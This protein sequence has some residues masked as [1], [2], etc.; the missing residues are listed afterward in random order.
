[1]HV[2]LTSRSNEVVSQG[3]AAAQGSEEAEDSRGVQASS[4]RWSAS[5]R[6]FE[7]SIMNREITAENWDSRLF[8]IKVGTTHVML[9]INLMIKLL[10]II[11]LGL[12]TWSL[13]FQSYESQSI[14][15]QDSIKKKKKK[16][17]ALQGR[18]CSEIQKKMMSGEN[19]N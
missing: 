12:I 13:R 14:K 16:T 18:I 15:W 2:R 5:I 7:D 3:A 1:M 10:H 19:R 8:E 9:R 6:S 4:C 17:I 11:I